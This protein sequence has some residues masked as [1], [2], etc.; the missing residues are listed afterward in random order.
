MVAYGVERPE[1]AVVPI[2]TP[3]E[4]LTDGKAAEVRHARQDARVGRVTVREVAFPPAVVDR[5]RL[6]GRIAD[7]GDGTHGRRTPFVGLGDVAAG[8]PHAAE[9]REGGVG[10]AGTAEIPAGT[11][12]EV[13]HGAVVAGEVVRLGDILREDRRGL[14]AGEIEQDV[15]AVYGLT[16]GGVQL[17][18]RQPVESGRAGDV[19]GDGR[20]LIA[21]PVKEKD[22]SVHGCV[23]VV[24]Q[25]GRHLF[26]LRGDEDVFRTPCVDAREGGREQEAGFVHLGRVLEYYA[27]RDDLRLRVKFVAGVDA[28][29][30]VPFAVVGLEL[31]HE[32][33][34][35]AVSEL[36]PALVREDGVLADLLPAVDAP[37]HIQDVGA[38]GVE[39]GAGDDA[40]LVAGAVP[41]EHEAVDL[42]IADEVVHRRLAR[43]Q[44]VGDAVGVVHAV[45]GGDHGE[46]PPGGGVCGVVVVE[47]GRVQIHG[48]PAV[49]AR[50]ADGGDERLDGHGGA[51]EIPAEVRH[52]PF[53]MRVL[54]GEQTAIQSRLVGVLRAALGDGRGDVV[55]GRIVGKGVG[56]VEL[57]RDAVVAG[58]E[59]H[60]VPPAFHRGRLTRE[61]GPGVLHGLRS[62]EDPEVRHVLA[63]H[64]APDEVR[65]G[66]GR[67]VVLRC[68][69][70]EV[71]AEAA[72]ER[73]GVG[74]AAAVGVHLVQAAIAGLQ[75]G[76]VGVVEHER[77]LARRVEEGA[78]VA[79]AEKGPAVKAEGRAE[80]GVVPARSGDAY[81]V[82]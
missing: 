38:V 35:A 29:H 26:V 20:E 31:L 1:G 66:A 82:G 11:A 25:L 72:V 24:P 16:L 17:R 5:R 37:G 62:G 71:A 75:D 46:R 59:V 69:G 23:G 42:R 36:I 81:L 67:A 73:H 39:G 60:A 14:H 3:Q 22:G 13:R 32:L 54:K 9:G 51:L 4:R 56:G 64:V 34:L 52:L 49:V 19:R 61:V 53:R 10:Y 41:H 43:L 58:R 6:A 47:E 48:V 68:Q 44:D 40:D 33:A 55:I 74:V 80:H 18:L 30:A 27:G 50:V 76:A 12:R 63:V 65:Q 28:L 8:E 45:R 15:G 77:R 79:D 70:V 21:E 7:I 2:E 57:V 78:V